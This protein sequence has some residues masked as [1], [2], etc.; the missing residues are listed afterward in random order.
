MED[1]KKNWKVTAYRKISFKNLRH[2]LEII[3][4]KLKCG[5]VD[6]VLVGGGKKN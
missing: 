6:A 2:T 3:K 4:M 5:L 1:V